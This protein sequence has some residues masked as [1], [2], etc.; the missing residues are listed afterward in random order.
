[1][2]KALSVLNAMH[3]AG[4]EPHGPS[5]AYLQQQLLSTVEAMDTAYYALED[6]ANEGEK[7][8]PASLCM[9]ITA[10][11][12]AGDLERAY[13]TFNAYA[14]FNLQPNIAAVNALLEGFFFFIC[15][16]YSSVGVR[17]LI[18]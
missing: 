1:M 2:K 16:N 14:K 18:A 13:L 11:S 6:L 5:L 12:N 9:I 17:V 15:C 4:I 8:S 7:V 3:E 10:C